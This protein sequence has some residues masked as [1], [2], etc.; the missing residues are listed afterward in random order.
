M[1]EIINITTDDLINLPIV[2]ETGG[3][4]LILINQDKTNKQILLKDLLQY[5]I[6][7]IPVE[8]T[9]FTNSKNID[10]LLKSITDKLFHLNSS[11]INWDGEMKME[12]NNVKELLIFILDE[13]NSY[14][15]GINSDQIYFKIDSTTPDSAVDLN[16]KTLEEVINYILNNYR[17]NEDNIDTD[18]IIVDTSGW[19]KVDRPLE[20]STKSDLQTIVDSLY[21]MINE[22]ADKNKNV[23]VR[24]SENIVISYGSEEELIVNIKVIR[25]TMLKIN[26]NPTIL[27]NYPGTFHLSIY[28]QD[29]FV[30]EFYDS[31]T[32]GYH[33]LEYFSYVSLNV[34]E[35]IDYV[36]N[37]IRIYMSFSP[38]I[39]HE[40]ALVDDD[41][42]CNLYRNNLRL[43]FQGED[44]SS[45]Q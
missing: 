13:L 41:I 32:G 21:T 1:S 29:Q 5:I 9:E 45:E 8:N 4:D 26:I 25:S 38:D 33:T 40:E 15:N 22:R 3:E 42:V 43:L 10:E 14:S 44:I 6:T 39:Q 34:P 12:Y 7:L 28:K 17:E 36:V 24:N 2:N 16:G 27:C 18:D 35:N 31:L 23:Y 37:D 19:T 20:D 11:D 30:D